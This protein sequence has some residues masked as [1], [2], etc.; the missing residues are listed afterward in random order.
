M[1]TT[2]LTADLPLRL[3]ERRPRVVVLGDAILDGWLSGECRRLCREAP[4]PVLEVRSDACAPGGGP[5][6]ARR[7]WRRWAPS[8]TWSPWSG[9]TRT[10]A[11]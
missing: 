9:T 6:T 5:A 8:P 11:G 2:P 10:D 7:T 3:A 1:S 4:A